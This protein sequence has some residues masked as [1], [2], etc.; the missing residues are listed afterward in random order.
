MTTS[1]SVTSLAKTTSGNGPHRYVPGGYHPVRIGDRF[2]DRYVVLRKFGFGIYSTVW[3][4]KDTAY[5]CHGSAWV[6]MVAVL[7]DA[8][9]A[10]KVMTADALHGEKHIDELNILRRTSSANP[11]HPGHSR[12]VQLLDHFEYT[13]PH[14]LHLCLV[15]EVLGTSL[16]GLRDLYRSTE[17]REVPS[18]IV[19]RFTNQILLGL[20]YL[21]H[22]CGIV[23][24]GT[25]ILVRTTL[26]PRLAAE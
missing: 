15:L 9:I 20:D 3:L 18:A 7:K 22:S 11:R 24:T 12:I 19:K 16:G 13:G 2:K 8:F 23:H 21:H 10:L 14:G 1:P 25:S 17:K 26:T 6:L 5:Y 4:A